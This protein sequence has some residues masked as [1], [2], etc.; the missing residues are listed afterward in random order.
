MQASNP[1]SVPA[2]RALL[3]TLHARLPHGV[4]ILDCDLR[5]VYANPRWSDFMARVG[6]GNPLPGA[7]LTDL[8]PAKEVV[9]DAARRCLQNDESRNIAGLSFPARDGESF[10]DLTLAPL[11]DDVTVVG[12]T[13]VVY[14]ATER[15][16]AERAATAKTRLTAFRVEISQAMAGSD[17]IDTVLQCC[18]E[19]MV[20]H[21]PAAFARIWVLDEADDAY[22]LRASAGLYTRLNGTY[23]R[24]PADWIRQK[25][26]GGH[27]PEVAIDILKTHHVREPEWAAANGLV[28]WANHP[29]VVTGRIIGFMAMFARQNFDPDT[30]DELAAVADAIAQFLERKHAQTALREQLEQRVAERTR[31]LSLLLDISRNVAST[32]ELKP[33]LELI[34]DQ[35]RTVVPYTGTA[36][37]TIEGDDLIIAGQRGPL[38]D[39]AARL[40]RYPVEKMA[41]VWARLSR[42]GAIIIPDVRGDSMEAEVFRSVV[43]ADLDDQLTFIG[44]CL[45]AP[46]VVKDQLIGCMS[47]TNQETGAYNADHAVIAGAIARQA[48]VAIENARLFEQARGVAALEE[49]QRLARELH[50]SVSQALF[51]IGLGAETAK[52]MLE[53]DPARA[54]APIDYVLQLARGGMAEMRALIFELRPESLEQEGLVAALEKQAAATGVRHGIEIELDLPAEP[55]IPIGM[56]EALYRIAQ[57][58]MHNTAKHAEASKVTL[59]LAN[60]SNALTMA[61][62][63]D[64]AGFDSSASFP[65]HL[66]LVSMQERITRFGGRVEITSAPGAGTTV[67]VSVP[68]PTS[69]H[70]HT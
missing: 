65:G 30:L 31:D 5:L 41:P 8:I 37:L 46:L 2:Q 24:V 43:G 59:C 48:A 51:G 47:I 21:A 40:I 70:D 44:S 10:W 61:V 57:E 26:F 27:S 69:K 54:A 28:A 11:S 12:L 60:G 63:D 3:E 67:N 38:S 19:A 17:D 49:R 33:L 4:A 22:R 34:L 52:T 66:G 68:L 45:W 56:K 23:S 18:A 55:D 15:V 25:T 64:G 62:I 7:P 9:Q 32:L 36:V 13:C 39:E 58:A 20:R 50:D 53:R 6:A 42:G 16:L 1:L 14:E 35:L 29:L